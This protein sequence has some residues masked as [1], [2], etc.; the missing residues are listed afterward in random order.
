M[1]YSKEIADNLLK[2]FNDNNFDYYFDEEKGELVCCMLLRSELE[3]VSC[4]IRLMS[5]TIWIHEICHIG[6]SKIDIGTR[7][8]AQKYWERV[9]SKTDGNFLMDLD[10]GIIHY[11]DCIDTKNPLSSVKKIHNS[12][13]KSLLFYEIYVDGLLDI[14]FKHRCAEDV[15]EERK[16]TKELRTIMLFAQSVFGTKKCD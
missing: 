16:S 5:D 12:M 4:L 8:E 14:L 1:N 10:E 15:F 9:R 13:G 2:L 11:I 7:E 6:S 3:E